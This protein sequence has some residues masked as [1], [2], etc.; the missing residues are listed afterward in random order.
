MAK[1]NAERQR[2]FRERKRDNEN[3]KEQERNRKK[4]ERQ[5][6]K[7]T[8][9]KQEA[10][11]VRKLAR[12]RQK[13]RCLLK[14]SQIPAF[15]ESPQNSPYKSRQSLSKAVKRA[16]QALPSSPRKKCTVIKKNRNITVPSS[17]KKENE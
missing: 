5:R 3:F 17:R 16:L 8:Q 10:E 14:K 12:L 15:Q 2:A 6:K 4:A 7:E 9:S 13:K 11:R 1:N